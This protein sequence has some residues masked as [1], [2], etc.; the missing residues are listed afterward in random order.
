MR[1]LLD[2]NQLTPGV[3]Q[4]DLKMLDVVK[5]IF[6]PQQVRDALW[7]VEHGRFL[8]QFARHPLRQREGAFQGNGLVA[9]H[10]FNLTQ[11]IQ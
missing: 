7:R 6:L 1:N 4:H 2:A 3:Q 11:L 5:P 9:P 8:L 10:A